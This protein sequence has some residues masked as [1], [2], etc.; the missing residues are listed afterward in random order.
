MS[1]VEPVSTV[2]TVASLANE[3]MKTSE[4][5]RLIY[6]RLINR[7]T[8]GTIKIPIFGAGGVGKTTIS[9]ILVGEDPLKILAPYD[10]SLVVDS[11]ELKGKVPGR[12]LVAP[13][14]IVRAERHWPDLLKTSN[15]KAAIGVI[16]VVA[17]GFHSL[18]LQ[19]YKEHDLFSKGME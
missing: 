4:K 16:N 17:Y 6:Q 15:D 10:E 19:H 18:M 2:V 13:G 9:R 1:W 12:L 3:A 14:Q 5:I 11:V 8:N 7:I